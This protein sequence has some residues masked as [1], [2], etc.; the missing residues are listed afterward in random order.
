MNKSKRLN[1]GSIVISKDPTKADYLKIRT[2]LKEPI[3]L[4]AGDYLTV[5]SPRFQLENLDRLVDKKL[6][7]VEF[8]EESKTRIMT[9]EARRKELGGGKDFI[10]ADVFVTQK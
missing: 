3:V 1:I 10:R 2:D 5:E 9:Q 6:V 8:A 7:S 4:N